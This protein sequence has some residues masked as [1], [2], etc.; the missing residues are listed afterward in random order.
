VAFTTRGLRPAT[1]SGA[2]CGKRVCHVEQGD[3]FRL[4]LAGHVLGS[5]ARSNATG[6]PISNLRRGWGPTERKGQMGAAVSHAPRTAGRDVPTRGHV[7]NRGVAS[8]ARSHAAHST[9]KAPGMGTAT[10]GFVLS[11]SC[12]F[13]TPRRKACGWAQEADQVGPAGPMAASPG[14][15]LGLP[16]ARRVTMARYVGKHRRAAGNPR[17]AAP[18]ASAT[19]TGVSAVPPERLDQALGARRAPGEAA[20]QNRHQPQPQAAA[21]CNS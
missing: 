20:G 17:P 19:A 11:P 16:S 13:N 18:T 9:T 12:G 7:A 10:K 5:W 21:G 6:G 3:G 4:P 8:K 2:N 14:M 1:R 15:A